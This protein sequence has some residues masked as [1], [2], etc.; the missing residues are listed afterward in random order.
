MTNMTKTKST[1]DKVE[2]SSNDVKLSQ[3]LDR[4]AKLE[5]ENAQ[6]K[7]KE[8]VDPKKRYEGAHSYSYK[9]WNWIPI[10]DYVSKKKDLARDYTYENVKGEVV[11][12]HVMELKLADWTTIDTLVTEFHKGYTKSEQEFPIEERTKDWQKYFKFEKD[13]KEFEISSKII[14]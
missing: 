3:I 14:N 6:L 1:E 9:L 10:I 13:W 8:P 4:I 5:T 7:K 11:D 2:Q 12:N